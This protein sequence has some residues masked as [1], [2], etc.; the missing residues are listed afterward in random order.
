MNRYY[1]ED[2]GSYKVT[3]LREA[4][5]VSKMPETLPIVIATFSNGDKDL[6]RKLMNYYVGGSKD[7]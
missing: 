3:S 5:A 4:H 2:N 7:V 1:V 6:E